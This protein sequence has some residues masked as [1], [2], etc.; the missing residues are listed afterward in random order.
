MYETI[1]NYYYKVFG[2]SIPVKKPRRFLSKEEVAEIEAKLLNI[3]GQPSYTQVELAISYGVS[4]SIISKI[5]LNKHRFSTSK[6]G[7]STEEHADA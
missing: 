6:S 1:K 7:Y 3:P 5:N 2:S 4:T